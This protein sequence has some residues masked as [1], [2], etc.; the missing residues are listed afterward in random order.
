[1]V[2]TLEIHVLDAGRVDSIVVG[3]EGEYMVFDSGTYAGGKKMFC[4]LIDHNIRNL[5]YIVCT[6]R[7]LNHVGGVPYLSHA[8]PDAT[9]V[10]CH[11]QM[12]VALARLAHTK[13]EISAVAKA[14]FLLMKPTDTIQLGGAEFEC[15]GPSSIVKCERGETAENYNSLIL[16]M[17]Y[18]NLTA[19]FTGDTSERILAGI[20]K[21]RPGI[22]DV[23]VFKNPHHNARLSK[24][25]LNSIRPIVTL[26]C[27]SGKISSVYKKTLD[28]LKSQVYTACSSCNGTISLYSDGFSCD[29]FD[30][31]MYLDEKFIPVH[32]RVLKKKLKMMRGSD[33]LYAQKALNI[34]G[35]SVGACDGVYGSST[36]KG[37][38]EYQ[39]DHS[40]PVTG[41]L[42][43]KTWD[44][45]FGRHAKTSA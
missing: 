45:L 44:L 33:V 21:N 7:H 25:I 43:R 23:D 35:Y 39:R 34:I 4:Y 24:N 3:C 8:F 2:P 42:D 5:K 16:R 13:A 36:A 12:H 31:G 9:L 20:E 29:V 19:L 17:Q 28:S 30:H 40:L 6:H 26:V 18:R 1:M 22:L 15:I 41:E 32:S 37:V 14:S 27:N 38:K 11:P 10:C